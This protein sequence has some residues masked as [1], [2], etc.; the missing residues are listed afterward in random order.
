MCGLLDAWWSLLSLAYQQITRI[1]RNIHQI[2]VVVTE[3]KQAGECPMQDHIW[4]DCCARASPAVG[5]TVL[6]HHKLADPF[7]CLQ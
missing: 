3:G 6:L 4:R 1:G 2:D 7:F 5:L